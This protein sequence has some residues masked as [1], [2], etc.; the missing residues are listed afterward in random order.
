[1]QT[2]LFASE[3]KVMEV[4]WNSG[5]TTAKDIAITLNAQLGWSKTTTYTVIKKCID[6]G[7]IERRDPNFV[8]H[9]LVTKDEA[10]EYEAMELVDKMFDGSSDLLV[11]ALINGKKLSPQQLKKL[12]DMINNISE[13]EAE[14]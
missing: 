4:L 2:G 8:C 7:I 14:Q 6:K 3:L 1:M 10:R 9:A 5:D 11:A 13:T 12:R